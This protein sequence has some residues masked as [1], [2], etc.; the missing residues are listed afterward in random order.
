MPVTKAEGFAFALK[1]SQSAKSLARPEPSRFGGTLGHPWTAG[2][3]LA[4]SS[5]VPGKGRKPRTA[6]PGFSG[7]PS[8]PEFNRTQP[9]FGSRDQ[10][11]GHES[12]SR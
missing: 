1:F 8:R 3:L 5:D 9:A 11:L 10:V 12:Q 6:A 7:T 4:L 2:G